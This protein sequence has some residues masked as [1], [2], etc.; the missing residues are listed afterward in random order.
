MTKKI[1]PNTHHNDVIIFQYFLTYI[2]FRLQFL[3]LV[4]VKHIIE[5]VFERS[6]KKSF[7][8]L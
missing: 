4:K 7:I 8:R 5:D 1:I 2:I 3:R 6:L